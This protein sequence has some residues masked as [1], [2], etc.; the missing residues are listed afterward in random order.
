MEEINGYRPLQPFT[1]AGGGQCQWTFASKSGE[2]FFLKE[3]LRPT[4]PVNGRGSKETQQKKILDCVRFE[5]HHRGMI[6]ALRGVSSSH[7]NLVVATDFFRHGARYYKVTVKVDVSASTPA[8]VSAL[9]TQDLLL[10][11][12]ALAHSINV[13]HQVG[14]VHG[15]LKPANVLVKTTDR[16]VHTAKLI[17][18]DDS[19]RVGAPPPSD[20][21]I[22]DFNYYSPEVHSYVT[23][24]LATGEGGARLGTSSDM[25]ALGIVLCEW[26]TGARPIGRA[27]DGSTVGT[28]AEALSAGGQ[29]VLP[30]IPSERAVMTPLL[31][32]L[33]SLNPADRPVAQDVVGRLKEM[34]RAK[35]IPAIPPVKPPPRTGRIEI[36]G[37]LA[38]AKPRTSPP[39]TES[40][41][42]IRGKMAPKRSD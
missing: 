38:K 26:M 22:G 18:F 29:A 11:S 41:V 19:Y 39:P 42:V 20:E 27:P 10:L 23:E 13:L 40:P 17:D 36:K 5:K 14:I 2:E 24:Q 9:P 34:K 37:S 16:G 30:H 7:G 33:L 35:P 6:D 25:F 12:T 28:C 1:T 4:F 31:Q 3:F 32:Q 8:E 21:L 15:D